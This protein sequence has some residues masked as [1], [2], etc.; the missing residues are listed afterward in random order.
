MGTIMALMVFMAM[1]SVFTN[2]Y[3]PVWMEDNEAKH[4]NVVESQMGMLKHGIDTQILVGQLGG[5]TD[6]SVYSPITL[7]SEGVPMFAAPTQGYL[8]VLP[9]RGR[10]TVNFQFDPN[11]TDPTSTPV[12]ITSSSTGSIAMEAPNRYY[13]PQILTY[14]NDAII[15]KQGDGVI[16]KSV[17]Q[18]SVRQEGNNFRV[19]FTQVTL[20]GVNKSYVGSGTTGVHT[21]LRY[22]NSSTYNNL[23]TDVTITI[24]S[25]YANAWNAYFSDYL[26][27]A[28]LLPAEYTIVLNPPLAPTQLV[29]TLRMNSFSSV[30]VNQAYFEIL[31]G[32]VG[33]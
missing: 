19:S 10:S 2:Q 18:F 11:P 24:T 20:Y 32:E 21:S 25:T 9:D 14:E 23:T 3:V 29:L 5:A 26:P 1:L 13:V 31:M 8:D 17:P 30:T 7:G 16:M 33:E 22:T 27:R 15:L 12:S 6:I 28:G 4:M